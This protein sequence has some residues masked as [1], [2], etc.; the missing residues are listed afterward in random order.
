M[1]GATMRGMATTDTA[2]H[3]VNTRIPA[4]DYEALEG[5]ATRWG[6]ILTEG[7]G[8]GDAAIGRTIARLIREGLR[9]GRQTL[10]WT[11]FDEESAILAE[12]VR[13]KRAVAVLDGDTPA[14]ERVRILRRFAAGKIRVLISKASLLGYGLNFQFCTRMI[15]SGFDDSFERFY[16]A[17]RRCYRYGS[18]EQLRVFVPFIPGLEDVVWNN[19][20]RKRGQWESDTAT[21]EALYRAAL[22]LPS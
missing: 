1:A 10:V 21:Q 2:T 13:N 11:V 6:L 8:Q 20:L 18:R 9:E 4:A 3:R 15:F 16:Q 22:A 7:K 14:A 5:I 12:A 17:V 19:V